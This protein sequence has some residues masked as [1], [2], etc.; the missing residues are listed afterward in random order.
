MVIPTKENTTL[1][2]EMGG[3]SSSGMMDESTMECIVTTRDMEG[4]VLVVYLSLLVLSRKDQ[5]APKFIS[6]GS[7][8]GAIRVLPNM[9]LGRAHAF[10]KYRLDSF[11]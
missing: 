7:V 10:L 3:V 9:S 6:C 8:V 5:E 11:F 1:I 4:Y 2:S